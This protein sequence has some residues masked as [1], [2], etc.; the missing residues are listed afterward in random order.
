MRGQGHQPCRW[1]PTLPRGDNA[2]FKV[3]DIVNLT[4]GTSIPSEDVTALPG[5]D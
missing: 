3:T 4:L 1:T 5:D 2:T